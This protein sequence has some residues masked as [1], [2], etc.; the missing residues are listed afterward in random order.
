MKQERR[1]FDPSFKKKAVELSAVRGNIKQVAEELG[2]EAHLIY[3]WKKE[4]SKYD[5]NSFPGRGVAKMTD[6]QREI[7]RLKA[8]LKDAE[9]ERDILKKAVSIFSK[10]DKKGFGL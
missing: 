7:A 2:I 8:A 6:E 1:T 3:R 5:S 4:F 10:S 9:L